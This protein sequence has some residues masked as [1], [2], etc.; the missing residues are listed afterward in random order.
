MNRLSLYLAFVISMVVA[1]SCDKADDLIENPQL[2]NVCVSLT[3]LDFTIQPMGTRANVTP[4]EAGITH[5]ALKVFNTKGNEVAATSQIAS[6]TGGNFNHLKLQLPAGTYTFVAI[7]H[8][9]TSSDIPCATITSATVATLPENLI[10]TLYTHVETVTIANANNQS[11]TIDMGT[12][13]NAT[14]HLTSTDVVPAGVVNMA[15]AI[16]PTGTLVS[17]TNLPQVNP[18][19]GLVIG[20]PYFARL[21]P[22]TEGE[23]IDGSFDILLTSNS[24]AYNMNMYAQD[25]NGNFITDY[26]RT[27][28]D[29]PFQLC[30]VTTASGTYFRYVT[31]SSFTFD[32]TQG[33][34]SY[35]Y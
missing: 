4:S 13:K 29:V 11:I 6:E 20:N 17:P 9:A 14:F 12:R 25:G 7:A 18:T 27:A 1:T 19:T 21:I 34:L 2:V 26:N 3:D 31:T 32:L 28:T 8:D 33:S 23:I 30:Y 22:V 16:N 15:V 5:I 24:C 10:P 35:E